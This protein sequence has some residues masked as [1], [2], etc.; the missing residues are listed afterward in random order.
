MKSAS[1]PPRSVVWEPGSYRLLPEQ[2]Q[3]RAC[4]LRSSGGHDHYISTYVFGPF[5]LAASTLSASP[6][7]L[8]GYII[9]Y[10]TSIYDTYTTRL[11]GIARHEVSY[12]SVIQ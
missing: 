7:L 12:P 8:Y 11:R 6:F 2:T 10:G 5:E 1:T 4:G 3:R 9:L